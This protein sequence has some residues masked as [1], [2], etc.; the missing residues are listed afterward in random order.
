MKKKAMEY[1]SIYTEKNMKVN[2]KIIKKMVMGY[3]ITKKV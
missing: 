3:I 1:I 2:G